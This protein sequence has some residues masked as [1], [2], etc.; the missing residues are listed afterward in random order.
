MKSLFSFLVFS[1]FFVF[2]VFISVFVFLCVCVCV[3]I[4]YRS[5]IF[6]VCIY[7]DNIGVGNLT[8]HKT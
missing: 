3:Y 2:C 5:S 7:C 1:L 8:L 4:L 6:D